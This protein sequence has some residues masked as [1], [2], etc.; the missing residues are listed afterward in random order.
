MSKKEYLD[1]LQGLLMGISEEERSAAMEYYRDY[2]EDAGPE[3]EQRAMEHL[4]SP[5]TVAA[6]I[7][8]GIQ[9]DRAAGYTT[10]SGYHSGTEDKDRYAAGSW[11]GEKSGA[12]EPNAGN[13]YRNQGSAYRSNE[14]SDNGSRRK[15]RFGIGW[16]ILIFFGFLCLGIPILSVAGSIFLAI[17]A[18]MAAFSL[19]GFAVF[20]GLLMAGGILVIVGIA[21][22]MLLPG[23]GAMLT[24]AGLICLTFALLALLAAVRIFGNFIPWLCRGIVWVF[25]RMFGTGGGHR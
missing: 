16:I 21:K 4:G 11:S 8:D 13:G 12:E 22:F 23:L 18:V 10:E 7:K 3:G 15:R 9:G 14:G 17:V 25:R 5:E 2:L 20:L 24:G 6:A 19:G 1:R